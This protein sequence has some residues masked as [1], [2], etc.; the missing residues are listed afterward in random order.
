MRISFLAPALMIIM[1][2]SCA[3]SSQKGGSDKSN[4][5][6]D[7]SAIKGLKGNTEES[8]VSRVEVL[9]LM[10]GDRYSYMRVSDGQKD[11]WIATQKGD[12]EAGAE[13]LIEEGIYKTGYYS[14]EFNRT[15]EEIYLVSV[16]APYEGQGEASSMT[17]EGAPGGV[18]SSVKADTPAQKVNI[19]QIVANPGRYSGKV[20]Q[21]SGTVVKVNA[22][23]MDRN[24]LHL[25]DGSKDSYDFVVTSSSGVPVGHKVNLK[26]ILSVNR[27]FGAGYRYDLI[28]EDA[29]ILQ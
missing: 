12:F 18:A 25:K 7:Y 23:I 22:N 8:A 27:D 19:A 11:F 26:G 4:V 3:D 15:F 6:I 14:S 20:L 21:L 28:L 10:Q 29:V 5:E 24:W 9:E 16:I 17:T 2:S 1:L 13:Y